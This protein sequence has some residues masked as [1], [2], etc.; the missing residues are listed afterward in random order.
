MYKMKSY[1]ASLRFIYDVYRV[2]RVD[3]SHM[4]AVDVLNVSEYNPATAMSLLNHQIFISLLFSALRL[5]R[6]R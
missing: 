2:Y 6:R 1:H 3:S 5:R 4:V